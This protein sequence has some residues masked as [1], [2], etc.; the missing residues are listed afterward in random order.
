MIVL[1]IELLAILVSLAFLIFFS[2]IENAITQSSPLALRMV[3]ERPEE[4]PSPLLAII[5]ENKNQILIP[6]N[7]GIQLST[8]VIIIL[9]THLSFSTWP[10][11]GLLYSFLLNILISII[12][13]QLVP[14]LMTQNEPEA[15]LVGLLRVFQPI[16]LVLRPMVFPLSKVLNLHRRMHEEVHDNGKP[17]DEETS[18]EEIQAYLEIGED[19]GILEKEDSKLI[20]SVVEFGNTLVREVMTPRTKI[21]ACEDKATIADLREIM[22]Q[23]RHS[24]IPIFSG[25]IDHIIG[26]AYIRQL[27]AQ[28]VKGRDSDPIAGLIHPVLSVPGAKPVAKLLKELQDRGDHAAI[29]IDEFGG[30]SGL[31]TIEDLVEEI[32]GEIW[33]EDETKVKKIIE[34]DSRSFVVHGSAEASAIEELVGR[35][36]EDLNCSTAAGLVVAH[37][38]RVPA[39]GEAFDMDGLKVQ[40]LD[41][42]RKRI[43]WL[44]IQLPENL[45]NT[46]DSR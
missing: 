45:D 1:N 27:V 44:R 24:R 2:L 3:V 9:S 21:V 28:Y 14:R 19:E 16:N 43:H 25:D 34:E 46:S 23:H 40:I 7:F 39:P 8:V 36:F 4:S 20:Q 32:V 31:V 29:V 17:E 33:D 15:K 42:D 35:K 18:G 13:R 37:L 6:L 5:L 30:V 41:A 22:V 12:F 26:I 11:C 38:G 10:V